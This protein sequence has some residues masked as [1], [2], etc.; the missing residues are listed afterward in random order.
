[1]PAIPECDGRLSRRGKIFGKSGLRRRLSISGAVSQTWAAGVGVQRYFVCRR[2][3][4]YQPLRRFTA[5]VFI[6]GTQ[7]R[8]ADQQKKP[9]L[10]LARFFDLDHFLKSS[11]AF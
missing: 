4:S 6:Q 8:L 2:F 9:I 10:P 3:A 7:G 11:L 5:L 1:M